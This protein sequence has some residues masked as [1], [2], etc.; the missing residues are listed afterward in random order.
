[1]TSAGRTPSRRPGER[2]PEPDSTELDHLSNVELSRANAGGSGRA[3]GVARG[4]FGLFDWWG[5]RRTAQARA[6]R[7]QKAARRAARKAARRQ[8]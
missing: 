7:A 4:L 3:P 5:S 8:E 1:M 2:N 6:E